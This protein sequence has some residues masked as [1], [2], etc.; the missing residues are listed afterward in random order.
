M[1]LSGLLKD[2]VVSTLFGLDLKDPDHIFSIQDDIEI[3]ALGKGRFSTNGARLL[4]ARLGED[5]KKTAT[6]LLVLFELEDFV[7]KASTDD[8]GT[9]V[10]EL[11][12]PKDE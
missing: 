10:L 3:V 4:A 5:G 1:D 6:N 2:F 7:A 8:E 12:V 11:Q 9:I